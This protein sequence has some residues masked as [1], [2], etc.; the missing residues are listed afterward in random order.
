MSKKILPDVDE[1]VKEALGI[2]GLLKMNMTLKN[3]L[4]YDELDEDLKQKLIFIENE[5]SKEISRG[6]NH[7]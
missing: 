4:G 6:M 5:S 3:I 7:G 1:D 2:Y